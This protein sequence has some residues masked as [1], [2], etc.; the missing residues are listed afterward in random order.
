MI[1]LRSGHPLGG[2]SVW[3]ANIPSSTHVNPVTARQPSIFRLKHLHLVRS[4]H[5]NQSPP[6]LS[7]NT[8]RGLNSPPTPAVYE[9]SLQGGRARG[10]VSGSGFA[11]QVRMRGPLKCDD[12]MMPPDVQRDHFS[13]L[14][15]ILPEGVK[16]RRHGTTTCTRDCACPT[17]AI[18]LFHP[19]RPSTTPRVHLQANP[20]PPQPSSSIAKPC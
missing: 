7:V 6:T 19:L 10:L 17:S 13:F 14:K 15:P 8:Y 1:A 12:S 5:T 2:N 20:G 4:V 11:L 16:V 9:D 18:L 3:R